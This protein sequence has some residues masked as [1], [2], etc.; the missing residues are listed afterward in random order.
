AIAE[1][2]ADMRPRLSPAVV[3]ELDTAEA[4]DLFAYPD[5]F[6]SEWKAFRQGRLTALVAD[7]RRAVRAARPD[8]MV[9][10]AVTPDPQDAFDARLQNWRGWVAD[11]LVDGIAPMAYAQEPSRFAQE[12]TAAR[13]AAGSAVVWAGI[14]AYRLTPA[15][16]IDDIQTARRLGVA[17]IA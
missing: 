15:Q 12:I 6:P 13:E 8:A 4:T 2:R 16:T 17:G 7:I 9:T 3:R 10:A 14:G 5:R 11:H 1:F